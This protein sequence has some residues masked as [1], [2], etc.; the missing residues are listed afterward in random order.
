MKLRSSS[1][2]ISSQIIVVI[3]L[4]DDP[5][6]NLTSCAFDTSQSA[7][8]HSVVYAVVIDHVFTF[9]CS[10]IV[11]YTDDRDDHL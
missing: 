10:T 2:Q 6:F 1:L 4:L 9:P 5:S 7:A 11:N 8:V 3:M